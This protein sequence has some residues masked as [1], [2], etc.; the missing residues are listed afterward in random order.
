MAPTVGTSPIWNSKDLDPYKSEKPDPYQS[1]RP[2]LDQNGLDP[3][4][5]FLMSGD[6]NNYDIGG[7]FCHFWYFLIL[8][9]FSSLTALMIQFIWTIDRGFVLIRTVNQQIYIP[10]AFCS[11]C[12]RGGEIA[13]LCH[14]SDSMG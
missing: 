11:P 1:E 12:E 3:Q 8:D 6:D 4:H 13:R 7:P 2:G 14:S 10:V 9:I 5:C